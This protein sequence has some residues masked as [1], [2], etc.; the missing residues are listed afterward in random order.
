MRAAPGPSRDLKLFRVQGSGF[1]VSSFGFR[2][3]GF[4]FQASV[5]GFRF[6][7]FDF[8]FSGLGFVVSGL[9]FQFSVFGFRFSG[10]RFPVSGTSPHARPAGASLSSMKTLLYRPSKRLTIVLQNDLHTNTGTATAESTTL[11][12]FKRVG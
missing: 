4:G 2:V 11:Y 3:S 9:W 7:V 6:S 12:S 5:F 1:R 10:F 8:R